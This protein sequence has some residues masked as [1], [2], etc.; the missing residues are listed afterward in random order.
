MLMDG[1]SQNPESSY[2]PKNNQQIPC[3]PLQVVSDIL[4]GNRKK[5]LKSYGNTRELR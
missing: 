5:S 2:P 4:H 1:R 3:N